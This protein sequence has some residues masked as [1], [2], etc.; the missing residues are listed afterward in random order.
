MGAAGF[1]NL[2]PEKLVHAGLEPLDERFH[3]F[4][5]GQNR[6]RKC[7]D[8]G[9]ILATAR[10]PKVSWYFVG[11]Y[12]S[13]GRVIDSAEE[14]AAQRELAGH[15]ASIPVRAR[16]I[17]IFEDRPLGRRHHI[18][19][20]LRQAFPPTAGGDVGLAFEITRKIEA[21]TSWRMDHS[22]DH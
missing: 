13:H 1:T 12:G 22:P 17:F 10:G 16:A 6:T 11:L 8:G 4:I 14:F 19:E 9:K 18:G 20:I 7:G 15:V 2:D 5:H 3:R 21:I